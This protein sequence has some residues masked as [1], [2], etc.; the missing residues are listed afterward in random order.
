MQSS[1][2]WNPFVRPLKPY[3]SPWASAKR[4]T[5]RTT[6]LG[7]SRTFLRAGT[8]WRHHWAGEGWATSG[9][10]RASHRN[11]RCKHV[12][13]DVKNRSEEAEPGQVTSFLK[14][15]TIRVV[16]QKQLESTAQTH[17]PIAA[18]FP[19]SWRETMCTWQW[20]AVP[21]ANCQRRLWGPPVKERTQWNWDQEPPEN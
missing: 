7:R 2:I 10:Q 3:W 1:H 14:N 5:P 9:G 8:R 19:T 20:D 18:A 17:W 12:W 4:P 16:D 11:S 13:K 21:R 15:V 6:G